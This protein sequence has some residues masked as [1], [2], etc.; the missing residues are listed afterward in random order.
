MSIQFPRHVFNYLFKDKGRPV[1]NK[2]GCFFSR[3]DFPSSYFSDGHF[4]SYNKFGEGHSIVF[5]MYMYSYV[6]FSAQNYDSDNKPLPR[7]FSETLFI[8]IVKKRV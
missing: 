3:L 2:P 1:K 4:T 5:P 6:K 8:R 7:D